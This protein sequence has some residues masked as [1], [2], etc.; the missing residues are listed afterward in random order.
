MKRFFVAVVLLA[1]LAAACG[2]GEGET[3]RGG[4][5]EGPIRIGV[6]GPM[7]GLA[8]FVGKNMVEGIQLAV[9]DINGSGGL[10]GGRLVEFVQR[11]DEFDPAKTSVAVR[12]LIEKEEISAL[13][14]PAS[15][16]SYLSIS[17]IIQDAAVPTWIITAGPELTDNVNP[18]AFR[19]YLP[20][21]LEIGALAEYAADHYSRI[22]ILTGNDAEGGTFADATRAA[23]Q[24][25]GRTPVAVE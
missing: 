16:S 11:D 20:D 17:R 13:F 9:E 14:G 22:A 25:H 18:Y 5:D 8:S 4:D 7:T 2:G 3:S 24:R 12:E 1:L 10:L 6:V 21:S 15:T 19:A 23:L